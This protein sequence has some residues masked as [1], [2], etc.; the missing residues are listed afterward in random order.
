M[1]QPTPTTSSDAGHM[2]P[3]P[4][5]R[6]WQTFLKVAKWSSLG[7]LALTFFLIFVFVGH[8]PWFPTLVILALVAFG[9]GALFH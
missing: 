2:D 6:D 1:A 3:A 7:V 5:R 8:A 9:L 4:N